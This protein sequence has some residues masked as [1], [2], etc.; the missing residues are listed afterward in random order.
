M[1]AHT[2]EEGHPRGRARFVGRWCTC[3]IF[4]IAGASG[5]RRRLCHACVHDILN[6]CNV[7]VLCGHNLPFVLN[8]LQ[9]LELGH[10]RVFQQSLKSLLQLGGE[11]GIFFHLAIYLAS[12]WR[13]GG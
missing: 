1:Q 4:R 11:G 9:I 7:P 10:G 2:A 8:P 5:T 12:H 6:P 13:A 3:A